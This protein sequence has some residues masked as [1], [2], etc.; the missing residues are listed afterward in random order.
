MPGACQ[1][2]R[3][4]VFSN[5]GDQAIAVRL[6]KSRQGALWRTCILKAPG[7]AGNPTMKL[8]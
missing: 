8:D 1:F 2:R 7:G 4:L 3:F 6:V 5:D